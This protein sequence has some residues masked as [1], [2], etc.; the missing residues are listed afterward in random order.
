M[1]LKDNLAKVK[2][3]RRAPKLHGHTKITLT[4]PDGSTEIIEKDNVVTNWV[5]NIFNADV[6]G[7]IDY[8][9]LMPLTK[10]FS[11]CY[12]FNAP[13]GDVDENS[14]FIP[15]GS[16]VTAHAG[17]E[18][19]VGLDPTHGNPNLIE[20]GE[21]TNGYRFVFDWQTSQGNGTFNTVGLTSGH[22]GNLGRPILNDLN[23]KTFDDIGVL[24]G[25]ASTQ[26]SVTEAMILCQFWDWEDSKAYHF[27]AG[28]EF[29]EIDVYSAPLKTIGLL[30][31]MIYF[32]LIETIVTDMSKYAILT[33][34]YP[35]SLSKVGNKIYLVPQ[36]PNANYF[37][38]YVYDIKERTSE[39]LILRSSSVTLERVK[40]LES[41]R[42]PT[43]FNICPIIN[44]YIYVRKQKAA[45]DAGIK[46]YKIN[47]A[48]GADIKLIEAHEV[49]VPDW[50]IV[51]SVGGVVLPNG[52]YI[53][54]NHCIINDEIYPCTNYY[55]HSGSIPTRYI[56]GQEVAGGLVVNY[57]IHR[58]DR[59]N[60]F[61][62]NYSLPIEALSTI[63]RL[64]APIVKG[65]DQTMKLEYTIT[66]EE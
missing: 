10:M 26:A 11:G 51:N 56:G 31:D 18:A 1:N 24:W 36:E 46:Y 63:N 7:V 5:Q 27:R 14:I 25:G 4:N 55:T 54:N 33:N 49:E 20:S 66:V 52:S 6:N 59:R 2:S 45:D 16:D 47:L 15:K 3:T 34:D 42:I 62:V 29:V 37:K 64:D 12:L 43:Y 19:Y 53:A 30:D 22:N 13:A 28:D 60:S 57:I 8:S 35:I 17:D 65:A 41:N 58:E 32:K 23:L 9:L 40:G 21:V 38:Y 61:K 44:G 50:E 39:E 48:N